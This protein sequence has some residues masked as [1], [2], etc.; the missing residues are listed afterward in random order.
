[1]VPVM[2]RSGQEEQQPGDQP[3]GHHADHRGVESD[4]GHRG[5]AE[6]DE[7]HVPDRREG[8]EPLDVGLG[9]A[10][11][12]SVD[13][14]DDRQQPDER[15][16]LAGHVGKDRDGDAEEGVGAEL[17]ED[18]RQQDRTHGRRRGVRIG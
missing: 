15:R 16:P 2:Q 12:R 18:G 10:G 3:V 11:Q 14:P 6:H 5:D 8:D 17:Q 13:D 4:I 7:P 9:Q 1:M